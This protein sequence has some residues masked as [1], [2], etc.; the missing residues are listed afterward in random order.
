VCVTLTKGAEAVVGSEVSGD[1]CLAGVTVEN[2]FNS[3]GDNSKQRLFGHPS[4]L[5]RILAWVAR[6]SGWGWGELVC[7]EGGRV[8]E[9]GGQAEGR[10]PA[11]ARL[12]CA[13]SVSHWKRDG[14]SPARCAV[15]AHCRAAFPE[16]ALGRV[17]AYRS[18]LS[19]R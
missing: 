7:K 8:G 3:C 18:H 5:Q 6:A 2:F 9:S 19:P 14:S 12:L 16:V 17:S 11:R 4:G 15:F 10:R 13:V 1:C